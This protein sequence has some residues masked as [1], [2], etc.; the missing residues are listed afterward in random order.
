MMEIIV[1]KEFESRYADLPT[2]IQKR[3]EKQEQLFRRNPFY[4]SLNT[5][6]LE[7]KSKNVWSFRVDRNYR[8]IFRFIDGRTVL[9]LTIGRHDWIYRLKF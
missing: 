1:T 4:P 9:F 8:I 7:P 6:K 2:V 3:A 5:E